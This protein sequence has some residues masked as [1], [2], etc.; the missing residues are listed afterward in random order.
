V[1]ASKYQI[2]DR[3]SKGTGTDGGETGKAVK[4]GNEKKTHHEARFDDP[5]RIGTDGAGRAGGHGRE[6]VKG[7]RMLAYDRL[8]TFGG[9]CGI[10]PFRLR[11]QRIDAQWQFPEAG[12]D[13]VIH[14]EV[15][16]PGRKIAEDS[17][18]ETAVKSTQTIV[19]DDVAKSG[20]L[21]DNNTGRCV[22][23]RQQP[24][25]KIEKKLFS[26]KEQVGGKYGSLEGEGSATELGLGRHNVI[27]KS[28][29]Y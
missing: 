17:R 1:I 2:I 16:G 19:Q 8:I 22:C 6:N 20:C 28:G 3:A 15:D 10:E 5:E 25:K 18:P 12:F 7:P 26:G 9:R 23:R 14:G 4:S 29:F 24:P 27:M 21:S 11:D 13:P